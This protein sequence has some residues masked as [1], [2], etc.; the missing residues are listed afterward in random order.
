MQGVGVRGCGGDRKSSLVIFNVGEL[1]EDKVWRKRLEPLLFQGAQCND[2]QH[3]DEQRSQKGIHIKSLA[4]VE[5][6]DEDK[7]GG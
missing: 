2:A 4:V 5:V 7:R 6:P 1:L 3:V